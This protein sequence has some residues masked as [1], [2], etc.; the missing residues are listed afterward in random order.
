MS[1]VLSQEFSKYLSVPYADKG[2]DITGWDCYGLYRYVLHERTG[3]LVPSYSE[4]YYTEA[5][6][7]R[8]RSVGDAIQAATARQWVP[9]TGDTGDA[10][11]LRVAGYPIHCGFVIEP[12]LMLHCLRRRGTTI[13]RYDTTVWKQR[14]EGFYKWK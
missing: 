8:D 4:A 14:V 5:S 10:I 11:V 12:G 2:R 3:V 9:A 13:E 7:L 6:P 1:H